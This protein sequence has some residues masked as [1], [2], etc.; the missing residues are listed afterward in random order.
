LVDGSRIEI[1]AMRLPPGMC[2]IPPSQLAAWMPAAA[3]RATVPPSETYIVPCEAL[4][5][6]PPPRR[7]DDLPHWID[8]SRQIIPRLQFHSPSGTAAASAA[9]LCSDFAR[10]FED[11]QGP[12]NNPLR[13]YA[14]TDMRLFGLPS[15]ALESPP[16]RA[17]H[18]WIVTAVESS[19]LSR[20][21]RRRSGSSTSAAL[22]PRLLAAAAGDFDRLF[23]GFRGAAE[24]N[25]HV[26]DRPND[27]HA[28]RQ[29]TEVDGVQ[30]GRARVRRRAFCPAPSV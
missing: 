21:S 5:A 12:A 19:S 2:V 9:G 6:A 29:S 20:S 8:V 10:L 23:D 7:L 11:E 24:S 25:Q 4:A 16:G 15:C 27:H 22:I 17:G 30:R 18:S 13:N 1:F 26:S 14:R 28:R 3:A